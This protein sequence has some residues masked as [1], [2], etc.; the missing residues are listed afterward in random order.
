MNINRVTDIYTNLGRLSRDILKPEQR[1]DGEVSQGQKEEN[2]PP[3][4]LVEPRTRLSDSMDL[5][6]SLDLDQARQLTGTVEGQIMEAAHRPRSLD[7]LNMEQVSIITP[8]Y[9]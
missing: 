8:R 5:N 4:T 7:F 1:A 2:S 3:L 6:L 9:V